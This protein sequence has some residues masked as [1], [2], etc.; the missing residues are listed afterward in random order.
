MTNPL[1]TAREKAGLTQ[2]EVAKRSDT[3]V[4][5]IRRAEQG[6][7]TPRFPTLVRI[8]RTLGVTLEELASDE[9]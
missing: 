8:A 3:T 6:K 7:H 9:H 1:L 2:A 5:T 4:D